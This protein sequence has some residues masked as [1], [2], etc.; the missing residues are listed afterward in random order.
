MYA[1][2]HNPAHPGAIL[3]E[4]LPESLTVTA[5][6][7]ALHCSRIILSRI[8]NGHTAV[9]A[10]MAVKLS[11]YLGTS[12]EFWLNVQVQYDL[13]HARKAKRPRVMPIAAMAA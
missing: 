13:R 8:L 1:S 12:A 3:R 2:M 10:D 6:A 11:E 9:S 7:D 4:Y 5:A